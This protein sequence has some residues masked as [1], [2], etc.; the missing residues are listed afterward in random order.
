MTQRVMRATL[1]ELLRFLGFVVLLTFI[2]IGLVFALTRLQ[3][4]RDERRNV[5][6]L[7]LSGAQ[8][9]ANLLN[10]AVDL[11]R[12]GFASR[13]VLLGPAANSYHSTL[14]ERGISEAA[15]ISSAETDQAVLHIAL[16]QAAHPAGVDS[17]LIIGPQAAMLRDIKAAR[18]QGLRAFGAP[19]PGP[20]PDVQ[21]TL[22]AALSYWR[23]VL[24]GY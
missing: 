22:D 16:A 13:I 24:V 23:Y 11:Y 3:G 7:V 4:A 10:H 19:L 20:A 18:D 9:D 8:P 21:T 14:V 15:L 5:D 6:A 1:I 12:R 17:V 2:G